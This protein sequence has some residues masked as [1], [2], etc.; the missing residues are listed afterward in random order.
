MCQRD[1]D[2]INYIDDILGIKLPTRIDALFEALSSLLV[3]LGFEILY[4]KLVKPATCINFLGILVNTENFT[5]SIPDDKLQ[6]ILQKYESWHGRTHCTKRQLQSLL[7]SL[8]Y[9]SK[10]EHSSRFFL[11]RLLNIMHCMHDRDQV[12]LS[13]EAQRDINWFS[14]F[15]PTFNG[16]TIFDHRPIA[17]HIELDAY[18]Q[19]LGARCGNQVYALYPWATWT[20][21]LFT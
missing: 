13:P 9:V 21:I 14:R 6:E 12:Q 16:I 1:F 19:D 2:I 5:L 18:L 15:L 20:S 8:L 3:H 4:N 7:G 10:C 11:N 17:F